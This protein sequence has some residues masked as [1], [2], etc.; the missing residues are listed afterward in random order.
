M[1]EIENTIVS[2][3][4][5]DSHFVCDLSKCKGDCCIKGDAGAPVEKDEI[6]QINKH[7]DIV[8]ENLPIENRNVIE[9]GVVSEV[10]SDSISYETPLMEDKSCA[11]SIVE[12]GILKCV[13]EKLYYQKKIDFVKPI[14]CHLYPV[15][16]VDLSENRVGVNYHQWDICKDACSLGKKNKL[17][18]FISLK[19]ALIRKFGSEWYDML[20]EVY[21]KYFVAK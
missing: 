18:L 20:N 7:I 2:S 11:Y 1:I 8:K 14:S 15:R 4:I 16:L 10:I 17:P 12:D 5:L 21:K 9:K 6:A 19:T 3:Q 13:F